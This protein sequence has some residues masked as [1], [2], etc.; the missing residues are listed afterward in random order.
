MP[1]CWDPNSTFWQILK[2]W[3]KINSRLYQKMSRKKISFGNKK[4]YLGDS[5]HCP[6][7]ENWLEFSQFW[8]FDQREN[9]WTYLVRLWPT[10]RVV[11]YQC[12]KFPFFKKS[13]F[14]PISCPLL[15]S[16]KCQGEK[17][18]FPISECVGCSRI[19]LLIISRNWDFQW[20]G[21]S[22]ESDPA[23]ILLLAIVSI[24]AQS[25]FF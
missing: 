18:W 4:L 5:L 8:K 20:A 24:F 12:H 14:Q 23:D 19:F 13:K 21:R 17:C 10:G 15:A 1:D 6:I 22:S 11:G 2:S 3:M 25:R 16:V 7:L 9:S